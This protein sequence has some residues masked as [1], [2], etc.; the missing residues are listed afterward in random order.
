MLV[1]AEL[2]QKE[3][4][5]FGFEYEKVEDVWDKLY[6]EIEEFKVEVKNEQKG[7]MEKEFGDL[8]LAAVS[9][10]RFYNL[11]PEIALHR[12]LTTFQNRFKFVARRVNEQGKTIDM[13][14]LE[15]LDLY[16]EEAKKTENN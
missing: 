9:V 3:A 1:A 4:A 6:E 12:S 7:T 15:E 11:S 2:L 5:G 8:L 13:C 16:W 10:A 14:S